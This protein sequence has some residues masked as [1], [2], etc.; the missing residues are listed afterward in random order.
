MALR[1]R[2]L[3]AASVALNALLTWMVVR[4]ARE[5][6]VV[7]LPYPSNRLQTTS[8]NKGVKTKVIIRRQYFNWS[9][10][11]SDDYPTYVA[12]LKSIGC[13]PATIRDIIVAD[14]NQLYARRAATEIVT[15]DQ[16]WWLSEPDPDVLEAAAEK[17]DALESERRQLLDG[18]L[19]QGWDSTSASPA[20]PSRFSGAV[21][22]SVTP[23]G[24]QAVERVELESARRYK[25]Y[26]EAQKA[27]GR[28]LDPAEVTRL[29]LATRSDL[30][31]ILSPAQLEEYLLRYSANATSLRASLK[32]FEASQDEF[33]AIFRAR[34]DI[35]SQLS[36]LY[37]SDDPASI[38]K[39]AELEKARDAA[40]EQ[41]LGPER[42]SNYKLIQDPLFQQAQAAV[43]QSGA[44]PEKIMPM[45]QINQLTQQE[46]QR[47]EANKRLTPE[48][49]A[50]A[51]QTVEFQQQQ[52]LQK[53]LGQ[54]GQPDLPP[55]PP[56]TTQ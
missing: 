6:P 23:E 49:R 3:V 47:I 52:A 17:A 48:Q 38:R 40:V 4:E 11:E 35:D 25:E 46:K 31:K 42:F 18:L 54:F 29:R 41:S 32:G 55:V 14:V 22:A 1:A 50:Q 53:V 9:D 51:L 45:Y 13:P 36:A 24:R 37:A 10:V 15:G 34:D 27:V 44:P 28:P 30:A 43:E 2:I 5:V 56:G 8:T 33:R 19:G 21:L 20:T 39:R 12:N 26:A 16:Q 7:S